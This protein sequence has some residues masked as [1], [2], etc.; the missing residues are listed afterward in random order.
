M[1]RRG[2]LED[3]GGNDADATLLEIQQIPLAEVPADEIRGVPESHA[4]RLP[5][6]KPGEVGL[7]RMMIVPA[8]AEDDG[9]ESVEPLR[10]RIPGKARDG[11]AAGFERP[12]D[13]T[14]A[15]RDVRPR[16]AGDEADARGR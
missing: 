2:L 5:A 12:P 11:D 6:G 13:V 16:E 10:R 8:R 15:V 9:V 4:G 7:R 3:Y 14:I 1:R